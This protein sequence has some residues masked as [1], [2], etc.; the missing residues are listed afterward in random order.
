M[1]KDASN[2]TWEAPPSPWMVDGREHEIGVIGLTGEFQSGKTLFAGSI[3]PAHTIFYDNEG[4]A[5]FYANQMRELYDGFDYFD[6]SREL[7]TGSAVIQ[8]VDRFNWWFEHV[9]SLQPYRY[10]VMALD[11][12]SEIEDGAEQYVQRNAKAFNLTANMIENS[13]GLYWGVLKSFYKSI[14]DLLRTKVHTF[15]FTTHMRYKY[16]GNRPTS[17][18]EPKGKETLMEMATLFLQLERRP[19]EKGVV[20]EVP[21]A[22]VLKSRLGFAKKT[23]GISA[24]FESVLPDRLPKATPDAIRG[25]LAKPADRQ[26][27]R[28]GETLGDVA[29]KLSEDERLLL[30]RDIEEL[31]TEASKAELAR[32]E[33][34]KNAGGAPQQSIPPESAAEEAAPPAQNSSP[35]RPAASET[36][37]QHPKVDPHSPPADS[38]KAAAPAP[39]ESDA[40]KDLC[41]RQQIDSLASLVGELEMPS[42]KWQDALA[43]RGATV[44]AELTQSQATELI[45]SLEEVQRKRWAAKAL[46]KN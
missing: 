16:V 1:A 8:S 44:T 30:Q 10:T 37:A 43:K 31:K 39:F 9:K 25:Y 41:T 32:F 34:M 7:A 2:P 22:I 26:R 29:Q 24:E 20:P 4:S 40:S 12:A 14:I 5:S 18:R 38:P 21:S 35:D 27:P 6:V 11:P 13:K 46:S 15:V 33:I 17:Q 42:E 23:K 19:N 36:P 45:K 3:D 28:A